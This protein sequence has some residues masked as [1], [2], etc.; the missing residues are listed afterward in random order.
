MQGDGGPV[1]GAAA[2]TA[3]ACYSLWALFWMQFLVLFVFGLPFYDFQA[4]GL[5]YYI[6]PEQAPFGVST[7]A[8]WLG[9]SIA[10]GV[11]AVPGVWMVTRGV[12]GGWY[13]RFWMVVFATITVGFAWAIKGAEG[14]HVENAER[15]V[16]YFEQ[17]LAELP[18]DLP[19]Y[20]RV[21]Y[22]SAAKRVQER[23]DR[24]HAE[25]NRGAPLPERDRILLEK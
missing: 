15:R 11:I 8:A 13:M 16:Q 23:L 5:F 10:V 1:L 12:R 3:C 21:L 20:D 4:V 25:K 24:Y 18:A 17:Q 2:V 19:L 7:P 14:W 6:T 9:F 22:K